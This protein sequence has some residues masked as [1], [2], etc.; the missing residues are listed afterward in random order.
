M[1][2]VFKIL[3]WAFCGAFLTVVIVFIYRAYILAAAGYAWDSVSPRAMLLDVMELH[4]YAMW[5][6]LGFAGFRLLI[7]LPR[8]IRG[9]EPLGG[10]RDLPFFDIDAKIKALRRER[11]ETYLERRAREKNK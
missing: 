2:H 8:L 5:G 6:G 3:K 4:T 10:R 11:A 9:Y 1:K 7:A